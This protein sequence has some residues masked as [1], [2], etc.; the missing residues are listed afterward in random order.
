MLMRRVTMW[1]VAACLLASAGAT[2]N[3]EERRQRNAR[4]G[5]AV[6]RHWEG[7]LVGGVKLPH[8]GT[9]YLV[10]ETWARRGLLYGTHETIA[11][12]QRVAKRVQKLAPGATLY[13]ADLSPPRGGPSA[14]HKSHQ[15]GL[16]VDL[17][18]FAIDDQGRPAPPPSEMIRFGADGRARTGDRSLRFDT[19]RNWALVKGLL[20]DPDVQVK[21][22]Y[23]HRAHRKRL[24]DYA[25]KQKEPRELIERAAAVMEQPRR[26]GPH[27]DHMHVRLACSERDRAKGCEN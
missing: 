1:M 5:H 24:L 15:N 6:G 10:P 18:F 20:T 22:I 7:R 3:A 23:I 26:A 12:V 16:D 13:V 8:R 2:A 14:W 25:R 21:R 9:G 11:F 27:D 19:R 4:A 17:H